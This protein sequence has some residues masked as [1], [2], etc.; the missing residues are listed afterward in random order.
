[1]PDRTFGALGVS[2]SYAYGATMKRRKRSIT[3]RVDPRLASARAR[4]SAARA[5]RV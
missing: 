3:A 5:G 1:M 4:A 2:L